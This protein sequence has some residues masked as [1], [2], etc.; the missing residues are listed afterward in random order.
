MTRTKKAK[1][2]LLSSTDNLFVL[3]DD[4]SIVRKDICHARGKWENVTLPEDDEAV[5]PSKTNERV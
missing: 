3:F 4:G 5:N 1:Q 2:I